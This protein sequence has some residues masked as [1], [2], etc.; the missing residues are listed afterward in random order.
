MMAK[1]LKQFIEDT[2]DKSKLM[3]GI[4]K[5][6]EKYESKQYFNKE[7]EMFD[8]SEISIITSTYQSLYNRSRFLNFVHRYKDYCKVFG[9][10][11]KCIDWEDERMKLKFYEDSAQKGNT[12]SYLTP[13]NFDNI[14]K[15]L[16]EIE[17]D[18]NVLYLRCYL[19]CVYNDIYGKFANDLFSITKDDV[20]QGSITLSNGKTIR[21][22]D[23]L[24]NDLKELSKVNEL[25]SPSGKTISVRPIVNKGVFKISS[26]V[27][28][29]GSEP[30][31]CRD[32]LNKFVTINIEHYLPSFAG[33][34]NTNII[35]K[36]KKVNEFCEELQDFID[37][38]GAVCYN[39]NTKELITETLK[40][41]DY[42]KRFHE[43]NYA[44]RQEIQIWAKEH[45]E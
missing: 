38:R 20:L 22:E 30:K 44:Y 29:R 45:Y 24:L 21:L 39:A 35:V 36:S 17:D 23:Q 31:R 13:K 15:S 7:L 26:E 1:V 33:R 18:D 42:K 4:I 10:S 14:F 37:L 43:F 41:I 40:K 25:K 32:W 28:N 19:G 11:V 3:G 6:V 5:K 8:E 16:Y 12:L 34:I 27:L 9:I 2:Y